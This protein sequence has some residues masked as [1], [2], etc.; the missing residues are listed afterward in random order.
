MNSRLL[1]IILIGLV[2]LFA[3]C[4]KSS[5]PEDRLGQIARFPVAAECLPYVEHRVRSIDTLYKNV[6]ARIV[7]FDGRPNSLREAIGYVELTSPDEAKDSLTKI[8]FGLLKECFANNSI[9]FSEKN[10]DELPML[11]GYIA[12]L[13]RQNASMITIFVSEDGLELW[14]RDPEPDID[15]VDDE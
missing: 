11:Y 13:K 7:R 5:F 3:A 14:Y 12:G 15:I 2:Q 10:P 1:A 9:S 6:N 4:V 8:G